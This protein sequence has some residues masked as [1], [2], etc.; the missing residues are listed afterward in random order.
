MLLTDNPI[1][2]PIVLHKVAPVCEILRIR[3]IP[4]TLSCTLS[5]SSGR[6]LLPLAVAPVVSLP[7]S[8][9]VPSHYNGASLVTTFSVL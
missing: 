3:Q 6:S 4:D 9:V 7:P 1:S 8:L 5:R 2:L